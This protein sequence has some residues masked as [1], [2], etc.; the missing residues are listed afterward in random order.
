M[1]SFP[2]TP[3]KMPKAVAYRIYVLYV[4]DGNNGGSKR[5]K[6]QQT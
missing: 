6:V 1:P 5:T 4:A 3:L 2:V